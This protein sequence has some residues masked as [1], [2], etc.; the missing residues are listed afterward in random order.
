MRKKLYLMLMLVG[1]LTFSACGKKEDVNTNENVTEDTI[2]EN[3]VNEA[4]P[5]ETEPEKTTIGEYSAEE[6]Y[7]NGFYIGYEDDSFDEYPQG[8][9]STN[10]GTTF[11]GPRYYD[12][13]FFANEKVD[14]LPVITD[15][16]KL[17]VIWDGDCDVYLYPVQGEEYAI[18]VSATDLGDE[19]ADVLGNG[20][21]KIEPAEDKN[22]YRLS[23]DYDG[24][25]DGHK[26]YNVEYINGKP[27]LEY[28]LT[29]M[30]HEY[31]DEG[32][33]REIDYYGLQRGDTVT[34]GIPYGTTLVEYNVCQDITCFRSWPDHNDDGAEWYY[35][36]AL[37]PTPQGYATLDFSEIPTGKYIMILRGGDEYIGTILDLQHQ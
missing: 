10:N 35:V 24:G 28:E 11:N 33:K 17:A 6:L 26:Y 27:A 20:Y 5:I 36:P 9:E 23:V 14:C 25:G 18:R 29:R 34:L 21:G 32:K 4:E 19:Y 12:D 2:T 8:G 31:I 37:K 13:F 7:G 1:V 16:D 15:K 3:D 22:Y 30:V